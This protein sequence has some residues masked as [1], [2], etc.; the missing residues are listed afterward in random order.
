M[1]QGYLWG[2]REKAQESSFAID[3]GRK[4]NVSVG[5]VIEIQTA[6]ALKFTD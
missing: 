3:T 4:P 1:P 6:V 2:N 5:G